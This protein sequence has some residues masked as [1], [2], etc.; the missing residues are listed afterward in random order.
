M[1]RTKSTSTK[2]LNKLA[3]L[4]KEVS[5]VQDE[6]RKVAQKN[7]KPALKEAIAQ[8]MKEVPA[9][10]QVRWHQYTPYFNDGDACEF[11][12]GAVTYKFDSSIEFSEERQENGLCMDDE[13]FVDEFELEVSDGFTKKQLKALATFSDQINAVTPLLEK[14]FGDHAQVTCDSKSVTSE[15]YTDHD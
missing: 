10:D 5:R 4:E 7:V 3:K 14:A 13:G 6:L 2:K 1:S 8:L 12:I 15:E 11:G 9:V